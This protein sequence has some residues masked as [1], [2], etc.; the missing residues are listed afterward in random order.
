MRG[1][2]SSKRCN[3]RELPPVSPT[4][5]SYPAAPSRRSAPPRGGSASS[6][7]APARLGRLTQVAEQPLHRALG[8]TDG[9]FDRI[10]ELLTRTPNHFELAV[11]SLLWSEHC[12]YKHSALLLKNLPSEGARVLQGP[13]ENAGVIDL[14][15]GEAVAFK[16]E[17]HNHPSAVEPFQGAATGVGGILRDIIAMGA[18]PV[19]LL[20]GLRFG[21]P[22]WHFDRAVAGVGHYGNC[23]GV[24]NVGGEVVFDRA[25]GD[26]CLVNA[27]CVGLLPTERVLKAKAT[28]PGNALVLFGATTGRD[29][30]GGA[31]VLASQEL[32]EGD[33][34]KRPSV[35][36]G[37]PFTGKKLIEVSQELVERGLVVALQDCGAA[38]LASSLSEMAKGDAGVDVRL[39][40]VPLREA[41]M[42]P[43]EVMISESQE[44]MVAVVRPELVEQVVE[45]CERWELHVATIG[46]VTTTGRLRALWEGEVVGDIEAALLT[47]ECP[48]YE[49]E[50]RPRELRPASRPTGLGDPNLR[51]RAWV[52]RP[53]DQ[54]VGSRTVR[55]PGLDA[56]VLRLRPSLRGLAVSL[57]GPP[58]GERDPW[59]AGALAVLD[60]ARNVACV[61]GRPLALTDC[62]NFGNPEKPEIAW[63]LEQAIDGIAQAARAL[64]IPVVSGNVSLYNETD[65]RAIPPTP[66]IGCVGLV[67]DVRR[68][69]AGWR[70]GDAVMLVAAPDALDLE[71]EAA[72]VELLWRAAPE[73]SLAHDVSDGGLEVALAEAAVWSGVGAEIDLPAEPLCGAAIVA[74][75]AGEI[76]GTRIGTVGGDQ[77]LGRSLADL[78]AELAA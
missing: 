72:L 69:P 9:E 12:G 63:E 44:R 64:G 48:R 16:V 28:G 66:V 78:R 32:G 68:V 51:S 33:E 4:G 76:D 62:L 55:R 19:A 61:G 20:D 11:F 26:N 17:S 65:G 60:A 75:A 31:S 21:Q 7:S 18:R 46:E 6:S 50:T 14:G 22:D 8:L 54:L 27:M 59:R 74:C 2:G 52:Y 58:V 29:G 71:A 38:G 39:D 67:D 5:S 25:Y 24:P 57:D 41:D 37:D 49:V 40:R 15:G 77:L 47:D 43:W 35:Q 1:G 13:G 34:D 3:G 56:A 45:V 42:E 30:I 36:V 23:T 73:V 53:Y 10:C 70:T